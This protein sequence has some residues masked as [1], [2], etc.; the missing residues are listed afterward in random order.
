MQMKNKRWLCPGCSFPLDILQNQCYNDLCSY[1]LSIEDQSIIQASTCNSED[2][3]PARLE[4]LEEKMD[5][6]Y[7]KIVDIS[8]GG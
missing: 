1:S 8:Y 5:K 3:I 2:T 4:R 6:I 7:E